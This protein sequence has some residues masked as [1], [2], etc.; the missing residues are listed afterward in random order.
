MIRQSLPAVSEN[1]QTPASIWLPL[2]RKTVMIRC[3]VTSGKTKFGA[4]FELLF[5]RVPHEELQHSWELARWLEE[6]NQTLIRKSRQESDR[7]Q[8]SGGF[9][10]NVNGNRSGWDQ[11]NNMA[12][13]AGMAQRYIGGQRQKPDEYSGGQSS[14]GE[15][16]FGSEASSNTGYGAQAMSYIARLR[17][18]LSAEPYPGM[19]MGLTLFGESR[20]VWA[21]YQL[22]PHTRVTFNAG[23][24]QQDARAQFGLDMDI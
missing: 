2:P 7:G 10:R 11:M 5:E 18:G 14:N 9:Q 17:R 19:T 20:G 15:K 13:Q 8:S 4:R 1:A 24:Q 21:R 6:Q 23:R 3:R 12:P 16:N 22:E